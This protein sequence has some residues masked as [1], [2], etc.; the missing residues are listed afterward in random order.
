MDKDA[1]FPYFYLEEAG[2]FTFYRVPKALFED[3]IFKDLPTDSKLLYGIMMDRMS[4]S[5]RNG[6]LD[7]EGRAY[8]YFTVESI[9]ECFQC[10]RDKAM[11]ML[12]DLDTK[13]GI[14]LIRRERQGFGQPDKIYL[15]N[16]IRVVEKSHFKT[17][18]DDHHDK[19]ENPT[20]ISGNIRPVMVGK[21]DTNKT[22]KS[23]TEFNKTENK[24][25]KTEKKKYGAFLNVL[26][27]D[28]ELS[29]LREE[30][31][32]DYQDRIESVSEYV[33]STGKTYK[34][35]LAT[36]RTWARRERK[37]LEAKP[38]DKRSIQ[39]SRRDYSMDEGDSL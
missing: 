38:K 5:M 15:K 9:S 10:G 23:E 3:A 34:N 17:S 35:Y 19:S 39:G 30:F 6:W 28:A 11:R 29:K 1:L 21:S 22:E 4:L 20:T 31:P 26:L 8:I 33:A 24:D 32:F 2:Q 12:S 25:K 14:G 18:E 13:S 7:P 37:N 27:S 36:I 16:F